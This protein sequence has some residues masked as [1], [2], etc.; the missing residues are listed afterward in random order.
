MDKDTLIAWLKMLL[1]WA[2]TGVEWLVRA[3]PS[4]ALLL[5]ISYTGLQ[6]YVLWRDRL[7]RASPDKECKK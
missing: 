7:R 1:L 4:V 6:I 2:I 3:L 5:T